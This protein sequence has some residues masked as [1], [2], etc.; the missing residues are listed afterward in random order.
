MPTGRRRAPPV[1]SPKYPRHAEGGHL[2]V[3]LKLDTSTLFNEYCR[4][5]RLRA[6]SRRSCVFAMVFTFP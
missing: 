6:D 5:G 3:M 1:A 4:S 2:I